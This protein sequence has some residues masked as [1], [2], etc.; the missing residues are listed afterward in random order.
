MFAIVTPLT[1]SSKIGVLPN[2]IGPTSI[3]S[4]QKQIVQHDFKERESEKRKFNHPT[5]EML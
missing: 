1:D 3:G 4:A 2:K 5:P